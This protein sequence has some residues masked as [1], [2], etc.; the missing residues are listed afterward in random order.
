MTAL[1]LTAVGVPRELMLRDYLVSN[2][3]HRT[4]HQILRFDPV[5]AGIVRDPEMLRPIFEANWA[6]SPAFVAW[7]TGCILTG[8][9]CRL[10]R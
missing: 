8:L 7:M 6:Y 2:K 9:T 4:R 5:K 10:G 3:F 1:V